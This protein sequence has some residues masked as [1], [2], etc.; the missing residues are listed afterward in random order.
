ML[1]A[2]VNFTHVYARKN[3]TTVEI[4]PKGLYFKRSMPPL[5][6]KPLVMMDVIHSL[7]L[8]YSYNKVNNTFLNILRKN[9]VKAQVEFTFKIMETARVI[10]Y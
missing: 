6:T 5:V 8:Q 9:E 4:K 7:D 3:Y 2:N 10:C 1:F